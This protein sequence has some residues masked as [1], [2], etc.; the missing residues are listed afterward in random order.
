MYHVCSR[1]SLT[2][3]KILMYASVSA[4][5]LPSLFVSFLLTN[6]HLLLL[7]WELGCWEVRLHF[8]LLVNVIAELNIWHCNHLTVLSPGRLYMGF[9]F[10]CLPFSM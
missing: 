9:S 3:Q 1:A 4:R 5:L 2:Y 10:S 7:I 6:C 8:L